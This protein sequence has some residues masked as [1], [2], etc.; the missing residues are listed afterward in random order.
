MPWP[1]LRT[2]LPWNTSPAYK[3]TR[4]PVCGSSGCLQLLYRF[5]QCQNSSTFVTECFGAWFATSH[6]WTGVST[7][8][9]RQTLVLA[10]ANCRSSHAASWVTP[11]QIS[12]SWAGMYFVSSKLVSIYYPVTWGFY[13]PY[14]PTSGFEQQRMESRRWPML[15]DLKIWHNL[16]IFG[17]IFW[18]EHVPSVG[19]M[20]FCGDCR[21]IFKVWSSHKNCRQSVAGEGDRYCKI[22]WFE[23]YENRK[24]Y[25]WNPDKQG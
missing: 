19:G 23:T 9:R 5:T 3:R 25:R 1:Y 17:I 2:G 21:R 11:S 7:C 8:T 20:I 14:Q 13:R 10:A 12:T 22:W 18:H 16:P 24:I 15:S 4:K 6:A